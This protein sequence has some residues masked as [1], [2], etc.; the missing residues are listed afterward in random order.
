VQEFVV[1]SSYVVETGEESLRS[2]KGLVSVFDVLYTAGGGGERYEIVLHGTQPLPSVCHCLEA[3][4]MS[5]SSGSG[6]E[7]E[8]GGEGE[9]AEREPLL[10]LGCHDALHVARVFVDDTASLGIA[11]VEAAISTLRFTSTPILNRFT[12]ASPHFGICLLCR[13][14]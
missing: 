1:V 7:Q 8:D 14:D 6:K 3:V 9:A 13:C 10:V 11:A 12:C 5:R 2:V 4:R